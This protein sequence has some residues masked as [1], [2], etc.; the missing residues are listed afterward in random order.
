MNT[1]GDYLHS[2]QRS[3]ASTL[4]RTRNLPSSLYAGR[5]I[6][7]EEGGGQRERNLF[8]HLVST[9]QILIIVRCLCQFPFHRCSM[10]REGISGRCSPLSI[11]CTTRIVVRHY[12]DLLSHQLNVW[13]TNER[14][15][16]KIFVA[17]RE[18]SIVFVHNSRRR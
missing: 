11:P 9:C 5:Y 10:Y 3:T 18:I 15:R 6:A 14:T 8:Y 13:W 1:S 4:R 7:A 2:H 12:W 16:S 17:C